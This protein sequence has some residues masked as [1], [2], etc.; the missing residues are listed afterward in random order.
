MFKLE[1][2]EFPAKHKGAFVYDLKCVLGCYVV[3]L[4]SHWLMCKSVH[5]ETGRLSTLRLR[6]EY[7]HS[8]KSL[9]TIVCNGRPSSRPL[10][11]R[12]SRQRWAAEWLVCSSTVQEGTSVG[13]EH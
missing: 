10:L 6:T 5:R 13:R 1:R 3:A 11:Y 8:G 2:L 12:D 4:W 7:S 9:P